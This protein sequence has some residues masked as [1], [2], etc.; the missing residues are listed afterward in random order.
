MSTATFEH[1]SEVPASAP[2]T[3]AWHT[4]PGALQRLTPPWERAEVV[5]HDGVHDGDIAELRVAVGPVTQRWVARHRD[6]IDGVQFADEQVEGP[7]AHWLHT[8]RVEPRGADRCVIEDR[9]EYALPMG[10]LGR[11]FG[12]GFVQRKLER[13]F[14]YRHATLAGD[15]ERHL[16]VPRTPLTVAISGATGLIGTALGAFLATG[17]HR[18]L[19]LVRRAARGDDEIA[20]DPAAGTIDGARLEGVDAVIHLA[21]ANVGEGRWTVAR[22]R[23]LRDSRIAG[24]S[25]LARTLA[26]LAKKPAVLVSASAIG[27]YGAQDGLVDET[28]PAGDGFLAELCREW[29]AAAD[30]ARAAGI[31]VAH[32]RIGIVLTPSGGAL[33]KMLP[34]FRMGL[35]A[36]LGDGSAPL[37]WVSLD[38]VLG[39][40]HFAVYR[41]DLE[42]AFNV[43]APSPTTQ[44]ELASALG[45]AL[46]RPAGLKVPGAALRLLLGEMAT[47]VLTGARVVPGRLQSMRFSFQQPTLDGALARALG[48][49]AS[50]AAPL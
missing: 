27:W 48:V 8:H 26:S 49:V 15:L 23:E 34:P 45:R 41:R 37:S 9:I 5:R 21:G 20:W 4:R 16:S 44:G 36:T 10:G 22:K 47:S 30:P 32:P 33:A 14:A 24:T 18:V 28:A 25:L 7:F 50:S 39:A 40:L 2:E 29:E 13:M 17:G 19:S 31:R 1:R 46:H 6:F 12:G 42:G 3:F 11:A 43:T 35:G 38:D